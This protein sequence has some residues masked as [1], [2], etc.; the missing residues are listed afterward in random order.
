MA[1]YAEFKE[2]YPN[3]A[4]AENLYDTLVNVTEYLRDTLGY[5][6]PEITAIYN[7]EFIK[8]DISYVRRNERKAREN[9]YED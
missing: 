9:G 1:D 4:E 6:T 2:K 7:G 8:A 3:L 5:I